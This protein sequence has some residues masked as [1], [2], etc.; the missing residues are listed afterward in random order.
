MADE[1]EIAN[2]ALT[3]LG[4]PRVLSIDDDKASARTLKSVWNVERQSAIR[5]GSWNFATKRAQ[6]AASA[7]IVSY[8]FTYGYPL[9]ADNL[10]LIEVLDFDFESWQFEG[11][12]VLC[13]VRGPIYVR[14]LRDVPTIAEW[15]VTAAAAFGRRLALTC[16]DK[17]AGSAFDANAVE[18]RYERMIAGAKSTDALEN[19]PI[20]QME[21]SWIEAREI[22]DISR[23]YRPGREIG[24]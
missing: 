7:T 1:T 9:P 10:R 18:R 8:P 12:A 21:S 20:E 15:D 4:Q 19:P 3:L 22:G 24:W 16:G 11:G 13:D 23:L 17:I 6:L 5:E 14:Y 2:I